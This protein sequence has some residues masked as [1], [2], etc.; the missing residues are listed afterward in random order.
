MTYEDFYQALRMA[1]DAEAEE[2]PVTAEAAQNMGIPL[3]F[4]VTAE[5]S[6]L[7]SN[8]KSK[9]ELG[10]CYISLQEGMAR[11]YRAFKG[12]YQP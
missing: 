7:S 12:V 1:A 9:R 6:E 2:L 10:V 8:E 3:P 5:E 11:T 4:P